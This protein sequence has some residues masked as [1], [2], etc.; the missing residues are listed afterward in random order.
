LI[1]RQ[2][3]LKRKDLAARY[4]LAVR[5]IDRWHRSGLPPSPVYISGRYPAWRPK[6]ILDDVEMKQSALKCPDSA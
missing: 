6:D 1:A 3:L 2:P 4:C 5:T